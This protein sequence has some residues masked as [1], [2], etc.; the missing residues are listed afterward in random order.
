MM[1]RCARSLAHLSAGEL[2]AIAFTSSPQVERLFA[3]APAAEV[4]AALKKTLVAAVGPV[5]AATLE[6]HG[7]PAR[8]MP[9]DA[10]F[11][12]PLTAAL[13]E[14]LRTPA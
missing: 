13:E 3:L 14:A 6:R 2:D 10:F 11:L 8:L 7:V 4:S 9:Q 12:K 5:V 1:P